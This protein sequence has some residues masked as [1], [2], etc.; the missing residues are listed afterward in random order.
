VHGSSLICLILDE[1]QVSLTDDEDAFVAHVLPDWRSF[2]E[3]FKMIV[4]PHLEIVEFEEEKYSDGRLSS[5]L[6]IRGRS[7]S[8]CKRKG[9]IKVERKNAVWEMF[10]LKYLGMFSEESL[11]PIN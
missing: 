6:C 7:L 11:R 4:A 3:T 8:K 10:D 1:R 5:T 9:Q 2:C